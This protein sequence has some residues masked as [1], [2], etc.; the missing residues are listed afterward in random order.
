MKDDNC[1]RVRI[2]WTMQAPKMTGVVG[3]DG[4]IVDIL[5]DD[6]KIV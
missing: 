1:S 6:G 4:Y 2:T 5:V 3:F